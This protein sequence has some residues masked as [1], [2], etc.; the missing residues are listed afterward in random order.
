ML[1]RLDSSSWERGRW[2]R[3]RPSARSAEWSMRVCDQIG[4]R[5]AWQFGVCLHGNHRRRPDKPSK[6]FGVWDPQENPGHRPKDW[7]LAIAAT[8]AVFRSHRQ[9]R[10][11][12]K[13]KSSALLSLRTHDRSQTTPRMTVERALCSAVAHDASRP[14][15]RWST[16]FDRPAGNAWL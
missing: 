9:R 16:C 14:L 10:D 8:I 13:K 11:A 7:Y 3:R 6:R 12:Q 4:L 1:R 5:A 15:P 2:P